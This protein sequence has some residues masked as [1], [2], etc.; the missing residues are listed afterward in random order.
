MKVHLIHHV[1]LE[2]PA[3]KL[4]VGE[5]SA[6]CEQKVFFFITDTIGKD[7]GKM[8]KRLVVL[9]GFVKSKWQEVVQKSHGEVPGLVFVA[10]GF[11][12][13]VADTWYLL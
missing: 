6:T 13:F 11:G 9:P 5:T 7:P 8:G 2:V 3:K 1:F 4:M 12:T 10:K